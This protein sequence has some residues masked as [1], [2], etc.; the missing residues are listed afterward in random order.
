ME[1]VEQAVD[2]EPDAQE[3]VWAVTVQYLLSGVHGNSL[4]NRA[5]K[6]S[7]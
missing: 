5:K 4:E 1:P 2:Q 6:E 7:L 3:H